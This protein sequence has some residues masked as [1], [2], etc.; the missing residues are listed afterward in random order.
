MLYNFRDKDVRSPPRWPA[1]T[2]DAFG[3]DDAA[4]LSD[5]VK[6]A[7][8]STVTQMAATSPHSH[9]TPE[10]REHRDDRD[11]DDT[12]LEYATMTVN[13]SVILGMV[14]AAATAHSQCVSFFLYS[15]V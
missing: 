1:F 15:P 6:S 13:G 7:A 14:S 4:L 5:G 9:W 10:R 12:R 8:T 3:G 11:D 2:D